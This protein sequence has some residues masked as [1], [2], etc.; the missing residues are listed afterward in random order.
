MTLLAL[1]LFSELLFGYC[2]VSKWEFEL[3]KK[4]NPNIHY[5]YS[6]STFYT[7][8]LTNKRISDE[9]LNRAAIVFLVSSI[10]INLHFFLL[11]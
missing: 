5:D 10:L 6:W 8:K 3:R 11:Y 2:V 1:T 4:L 9:F 7:Y